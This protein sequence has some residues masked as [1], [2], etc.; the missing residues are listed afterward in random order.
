MFL[1]IKDVYCVLLVGPGVPPDGGG[2]G[3]GG[4]QVHAQPDPFLDSR[5]IIDVDPYQID[6]N[7]DP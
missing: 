2:G 6:A 4:G 7:Q 1:L 3:Y 5:L